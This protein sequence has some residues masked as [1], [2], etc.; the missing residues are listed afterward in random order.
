MVVYLMS[1]G[2]D[3][4]MVDGEGY[5]CLHLASMFSHSSIVAYLLAK[6]YDVDTPDS[7][8][9]TPLMWACYRTAR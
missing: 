4:T 3:P 7:S 8:G 6:G 5:Q 1:H 2:A 9:M